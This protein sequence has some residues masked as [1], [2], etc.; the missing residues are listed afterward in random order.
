MLSFGST[1]A[2]A[3]LVAGYMIVFRRAFSV[4]DRVTIGDVTG[5]V[6]EMRLQVTH[7]RT[8]KNEKITIPNSAILGSEVLNYSKPAREGKLILHTEVGIGRVTGLP[9]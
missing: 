1:S 8:A 9:E 2:V 4:G 5:A 7:L 6:T 3:N